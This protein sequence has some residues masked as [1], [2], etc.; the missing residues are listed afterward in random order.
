MQKKLPNGQANRWLAGG[1]RRSVSPRH[2]GRYSDREASFGWLFP[3]YWR[4]RER[5]GVVP[6]PYIGDGW[7][8]VGRR[9]AGL[10][11]TW[12]STAPL[13]RVRLAHGAVGLKPTRATI[14]PGRAKIIKP[15]IFSIFQTDLNL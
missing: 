7:P 13:S 9:L 10:A 8:T 11:G 12:H 6:V 4:R 2:W 3:S 14:P 1:E 15:N 5:E